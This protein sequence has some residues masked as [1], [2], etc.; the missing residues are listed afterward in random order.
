MNTSEATTEST[1]SGTQIREASAAS[2]SRAFPGADLESL[3]THLGLASVSTALAKELEA[4]V[5]RLGFDLTRPRYTIVRMLYLASDEALSQSALAQML[6]VSGPYM[7]QLIDTLADDGW[8]ERIVKKPDRRVTYVQLTPEGRE[9]CA[10]LV[11]A[12][13]DYMIESIS[14]LTPDERGQLTYLAGKVMANLSAHHN[15]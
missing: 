4:R 3:Q 6:D 10:K 8:V 2:Y 9:R 11:P 13:V 5:T 15:R 1:E 7:T 12:I 14:C